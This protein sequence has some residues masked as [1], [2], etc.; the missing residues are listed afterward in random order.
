M[1]YASI[2]RVEMICL[3]SNMVL[4]YR[5]EMICLSSNMVLTYR[6]EMICLPSNMVLTCRVEMICLPSNMVQ[7]SIHFLNFKSKYEVSEWLLFNVKSAFQQFHGKNKLHSMR[8]CM[9]CTRTTLSWN[10]VVLVQWNNR[11]WVDMLLHSDTLSWI[12]AYQSLL[13]LFNAACFV[14]K[15]QMSNL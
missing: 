3:P 11:Q 13:F 14:E 1:L 15:Q 6:V 5:V 4:T 12:R 2:Y 7:F 8:F 9:L 10:F